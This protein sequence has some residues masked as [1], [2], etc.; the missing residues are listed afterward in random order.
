MDRQSNR[1]KR[2]P[3]ALM[4]GAGLLLAATACHRQAP[5]PLPHHSIDSLREALQRAAATS[6]PAPSLANHRFDLTIKPED[7]PAKAAEITSI[8]KEMK[9]TVLSSP[10]SDS[11]TSLLIS[12][13]ANRVAD[14]AR[15]IG[16]TS[17]PTAESSELPVMLEIRITPSA[18]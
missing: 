5:K 12:L 1:W 4:L 15:R 6:L 7:I 9:G 11:G 10:S 17:V 2:I 8:G 16:E 18:E 14:F 3:T 13:P